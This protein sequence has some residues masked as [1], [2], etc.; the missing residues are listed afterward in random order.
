M[1]EVELHK[2]RVLLVDG[3]LE[4]LNE[5][6]LLLENNGYEVI[7]VQTGNEG[8]E[9]MANYCPDVVLADLALPDMTG[10]ELLKQ[11]KASASEM[12]IFLMGAHITPVL[13]CEAINFGAI[14]LIYK[15]FVTCSIIH[16]IEYLLS[17]DPRV[18]CNG[19]R[20]KSA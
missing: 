20:K 3:D 9:R 18:G 1:T 7:A 4:S 12:H 13:I 6:Q 2:V 14:E 17:H 19:D 15:A 10:I 5:L 8:L 16:K 11:M